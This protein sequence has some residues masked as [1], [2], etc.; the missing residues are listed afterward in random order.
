MH[1][2]TEECERFVKPHIAILAVIIA[3]CVS[4]PSSSRDIDSLIQYYTAQPADA[5]DSASLANQLPIDGLTVQSVDFT[6]ALRQRVSAAFHRPVRRRAIA[7]LAM[8]A[9]DS[10]SMVVAIQRI[11]QLLGP[12]TDEWCATRPDGA[13]DRV[14]VWREGRNAGII[15]R[16]P[17]E[18]VL[19]SHLR[20]EGRLVFVRRS[21]QPADAGHSVTEL[22]CPTIATGETVALTGS[23]AA[24]CRECL[25]NRMRAVLRREGA[26]FPS[27]GV[28][29]RSVN[30][31]SGNP[32]SS[33]RSFA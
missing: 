23:R 4:R 30:T 28:R 18:H 20:W 13:L 24:P 25:V 10:V 17:A 22:P 19:P 6:G 12:T 16:T 32:R 9:S 7:R 1:V 31:R 21:M 26:P 5:F 11:A 2:A 14:R 3:G 15:A 27:A 29:L 8:V 33:L